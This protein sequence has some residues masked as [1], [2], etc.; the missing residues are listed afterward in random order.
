VKTAT[1]SLGDVADFVR[2][3]TFK[4]S[5]ILAG[6]PV[7]GTVG[8]MRTSNVQDKLDLSD[9]FTLPDTFMR[10][11]DQLLREG[12]MLMSTANSW[13]LVGKTCWVPHLD[14]PA[15]AGGFISILRAKIDK[16]YPRYVYHWVRSPNTQ[17]LLRNCARQTTN[18][19][20]LSI[21]QACAL[22]FPLPPLSEQKRIADILNKADELREKRKQSIAKLDELLQS[23]FLDMF[24]DPVTNPKGWDVKPLEQICKRVTDGTHQSPEW[25]DNGVP[26]LFVSNIVNGEIVHETDKFITERCWKM[27]TARCPIEVGDILY[28][29]VG[30]YGNA[31]I[32]RCNQRFCFQRHI[33][34]IKPD[35]QLVEPEYLLGLLQSTA[36]KHQ[37]D[38]LVKGIAQ[39]TLN[40]KH[41][42]DINVC[43]PKRALQQN[44][45]HVRRIVEASL[46]VSEK[47]N[48]HL[49]SLSLSMQQRAF[50]GDL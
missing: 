32:V 33:A 37:V 3:I 21:D 45:V 29:T 39:K 7:S 13:N 43:L 31:A 50:K 17:V 36:V 22:P 44:Y 27:L 41:L 48:N 24:G 23:V 40:L 15:T 28:T 46:S 20:N 26:F 16:A 18:I 4:P 9:V 2:G 11:K 1:A 12:D 19:S 14:Y 35:P 47:H 38:G 42:K 10:H 6:L 5:D 30:S 49:G 8:C 25:A 34:H